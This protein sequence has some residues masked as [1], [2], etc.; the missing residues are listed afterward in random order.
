VQS[1]EEDDADVEVSAPPTKKS[2]STNSIKPEQVEDEDKLPAQK[3]KSKKMVKAEPVEHEDVAE[4]AAADNKKGRAKTNHRAQKLKTEPEVDEDDEELVPGSTKHNKDIGSKAPP[5]TGRGRKRGSAAAAT[6]SSD[7]I[8]A[9]T[10]T[11][12][13]Q[14]KAN[15]KPIAALGEVVDNASAPATKARKG[16]AKKAP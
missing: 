4:A 3:N 9:D 6:S 2:R 1:K 10:P 11:S 15:S 14:R 13:T 5:T 7:P 12:A 8:L 16:R